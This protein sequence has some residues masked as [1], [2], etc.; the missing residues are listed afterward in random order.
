MTV[1]AFVCN[2]HMAKTLLTRASWNR[3]STLD[4]A[5]QPFVTAM[6]LLYERLAIDQRSCHES[7]NDGQ[8]AVNGL[9]LCT[10]LSSSTLDLCNL[11]CPTAIDHVNV[12]KAYGRTVERIQITMM[13]KEERPYGR[14]VTEST[15]RTKWPRLVSVGHDG[16]LTVGQLSMVVLEIL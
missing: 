15:E 7:C 14:D 12:V 10:C 4:L 11:H 3:L 5:I 9:W 13:R 8:T 1:P 2:S 16:P 6:R